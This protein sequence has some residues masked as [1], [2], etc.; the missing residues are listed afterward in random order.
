MSI[1]SFANDMFLNI[2]IARFVVEGDLND[3][4]LLT[5]L[6]NLVHFTHVLH[7]AAQVSINASHYA[8][9]EMLGRF[10]SPSSFQ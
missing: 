4:V 5:K 3:Q 10:S 7:L 6:F 8:M 1:V 9:N 2:M